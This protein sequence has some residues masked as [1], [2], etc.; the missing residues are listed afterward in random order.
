MWIGRICLGRL[1][2]AMFGAG[3]RY[4][5]PPH[6]GRLEPVSAIAALP[7]CTAGIAARVIAGAAA[8]LVA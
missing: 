8:S 2:V 5:S 7:G 6:F 4:L 3:R 1:I